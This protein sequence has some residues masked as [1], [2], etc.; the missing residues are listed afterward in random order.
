MRS[1]AAI[2]QRGMLGARAGREDRFR[3]V[4]LDG[5]RQPVAGD[6]DEIEERG[7]DPQ[8]RLDAP[9]PR[10]LRRGEL[11]HGRPSYRRRRRERPPGFPVSE[12]ARRLLQP[13]A[14]LAHQGHGLGEDRGHHGAQLLRLLLRRALDVHA[15]HRRDRQLHREVDRV[16]GPRQALL[17][18]HLLRELR[19]PALELVGIA[20]QTTEAFH[21][22][23]CTAASPAARSASRCVRPAWMTSLNDRNLKIQNS[24]AKPTARLK[25]AIAICWPTEYAA[26]VAPAAVPANTLTKNACCTPAPPGVNGTAAAT[27]LTPSTSSTLRTD[28]PMWN[29]SSRNQNAVKRHSQPANWTANTSRR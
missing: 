26:T 11:R 19:H 25:A 7:G 3:V 8:A 14:R 4:A 1:V 10:Q 17:A 6:Q 5:A 16:V 18:L 9:A 29:A 23:Y 24:A 28:P 20:E 27:A 15:V 2:G 21:G 22:P 12:P 13:L